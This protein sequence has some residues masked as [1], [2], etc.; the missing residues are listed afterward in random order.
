MPNFTHKFQTWAV[1]FRFTR[2]AGL[3]GERGVEGNLSAEFWEFCFGIQWGDLKGHP[4]VIASL[5]YLDIFSFSRVHG[6]LVKKSSHENVMNSCS[7]STNAR[8]RTLFLNYP[9]AIL[10]YTY[11]N[12]YQHNCRNEADIQ[13]RDWACHE[14]RT[15]RK[16]YHRKRPHEEKWAQCAKRF[17]HF[18]LVISVPNFKAQ[19]SNWDTRSRF[20]DVKLRTISNI[21]TSDSTLF[22]RVLQILY[23]SSSRFFLGNKIWESRD[24]SIRHKFEKIKSS[25]SIF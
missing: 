5:G 6:V 14:L 13:Y 24:M 12:K 9:L 3:E 25:A 18:A 4:D 8:S 16:I 1:R 23:R 15:K 21:R 11:R 10:I 22:P 17:R 20:I 7:E 19:L 2:W